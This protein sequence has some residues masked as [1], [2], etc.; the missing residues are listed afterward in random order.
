MKFVFGRSNLALT[1]FVPFDCKN[2]CSFCESKANYS[3]FGANKED[4]YFQLNRVLSEFVYPIK[5]IVFTGGEPMA[6]LDELKRL[7]DIVPSV[8]NVYINTCLLKTGLKDFIELVNKNDKVKGVNVS[9]HCETYKMDCVMLNDIAQDYVVALFEKPVRINCVVGSQDLEAIMARWEIYAG[10]VNLC[11]RRDFNRDMDGNELHNMYD[12]FLMRLVG[13]GLEYYNHRQCKVCDTT[14]FKR[15]EFVVSY[16]KGMKHS[17]IYNKDADMLEINDLIILQDGRLTYDWEDSKICIM[18]ELE[19]QYKRS[20][21]TPCYIPN[22]KDNIMYT[23][24]L[25]MFRS[26]GCGCNESHELCGGG[27]GGSSNLYGYGRCGSG[28]C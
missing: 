18:S 13:L 7:I 1:V 22:Y 21:P 14:R 26:S 6:D 20:I 8:Y 23:N 15:G 11:F 17:S 19:S 27:C 9:R 25:A 24:L 2:N 12:P 4:V 10:N 5:D 28:G 3:R 16:H